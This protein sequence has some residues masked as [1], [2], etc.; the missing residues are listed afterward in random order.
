MVITDLTHPFELTLNTRVSDIYSPNLLKLSLDEKVTSA[1]KLFRDSRQRIA[2]VVDRYDKLQGVVTRGDILVVTSSKS[3]ALIKDVMSPPLVTTTPD[4]RVSAILPRMLRVDEWYVPVTQNGK[5]VGVLG[6]EHIIQRMLDENKEYLET[7]RVETI[8]SKDVVSVE[9]NDHVNRVWDK[10]VEYKYAGLPVVDEKGRL[11]GIITQY[12]L[13]ARG[14]RISLESSS[15]PTRLAKIREVMTSNVVYIYP[16]DTVEKAATVMV[17]KGFGR[18]PV[19]SDAERRILI[20][21]VDRE[22]IVRIL[23]G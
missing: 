22:D 8:M 3:T 19:V 17:S 11:V 5:A 12:D 10:M 18:L 20:G 6:L 1:R 21:I 16:W 7:V 15:G 2:L 4:E 13:L 14:V 9:W 23:V